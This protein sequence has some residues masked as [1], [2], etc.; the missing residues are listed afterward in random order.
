MLEWAQVLVEIQW[1][2]R[3]E[4]SSWFFRLLHLLL[5]FA[6][7]VCVCLPWHAYKGKGQMA[8]VSS[9]LA[10]SEVSGTKLRP[11][12]LLG[13]PLTWR[14][15]RQPLSQF[16]SPNAIGQNREFPCTV[17]MLRRAAL[18]QWFSE[19]PPSSSSHLCSLLSWESF[20]SIFSV[21]D[22]ETSTWVPLKKC[23]ILRAGSAFC[24]VNIF[25]YLRKAKS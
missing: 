19:H 23:D 14:P 1:K 7:C 9:I 15:F 16:F 22:L 6:Y 2:Q 13:S 24:N 20:T 21:G 25:L 18:R 10:L 8:G 12:S 11:S 3:G 5:I 17:P 4:T